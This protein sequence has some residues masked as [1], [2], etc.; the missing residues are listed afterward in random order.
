MVEYLTGDRGAAG[1]S[2]TGVTVLCPLA[3]HSNL[4]HLLKYLFGICL[5]SML[6]SLSNISN[7]SEF[8]LGLIR[9]GLAD[10]SPSTPFFH[11][12]SKFIILLYKF[13]T[14]RWSY[15][16]AELLWLITVFTG[17][18]LFSCYVSSILIS[19]PFFSPCPEY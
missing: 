17:Q 15:A 12:L 19:I 11:I 7:C 9:P 6:I 4:H 13:F 3:R 5:C 16:L 2:L 18:T 10:P 1:T 8:M 14:S